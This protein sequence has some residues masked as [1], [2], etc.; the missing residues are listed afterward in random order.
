MR[1]SF[2]SAS[3]HATIHPHMENI[4]H[5]KCDLTLVLLATCLKE[6]ENNLDSLQEQTTARARWETA[7]QQYIISTTYVYML[8]EIV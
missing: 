4:K 1:T 5:S 7:E 6:W 3:F 8:N 2:E